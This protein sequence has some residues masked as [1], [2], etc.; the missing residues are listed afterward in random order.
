[1]L[2]DSNRKKADK[3]TGQN[4]PFNIQ[5]T[6]EQPTKLSVGYTPAGTSAKY[7][8]IWTDS[9]SFD[10]SKT[11]NIALAW[12]TLAGNNANKLEMWYVV[13]STLPFSFSSLP[14]S[15]KAVLTT[16][17]NN[18]LDGQ[19]VFSKSGLDLWTGDTYPN[20]GIYRGEKGNHDTTGES[21]VFDLWVYRVQIS[22]ASLEEVSAASGI[23]SN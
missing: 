9:A 11:H 1:M 2:T 23:G 12:D 5:F 20:F 16:L 19:S 22:D 18:R 13:D 8:T 7:G 10:T 14:S 17:P 3:S 21:N 6:E 4:I 15:S